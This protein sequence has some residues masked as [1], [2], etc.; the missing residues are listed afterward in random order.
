[1]AGEAMNWAKVATIL[2]AASL[3]WY[4]VTGVGWWAPLD[5]ANGDAGRWLILVT[6][7]FVGLIAWPLS[8]GM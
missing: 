1:M 6:A 5:M 3:L 4:G 8:E 2:S 7:H